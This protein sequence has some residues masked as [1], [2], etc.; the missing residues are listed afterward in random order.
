VSVTTIHGGTA[1]N[2]LPPEVELGE[3]TYSFLLVQHLLLWKKSASRGNWR[4]I[5]RLDSGAGEDCCLGGWVVCFRAHVIRGARTSLSNMKVLQLVWASSLTRTAFWPCLSQ[6]II[7]CISAI[8][9]FV[10]SH[11]SRYLCLLGLCHQLNNE[12]SVL[13]LGGLKGVCSCR[14]SAFKY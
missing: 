3:A 4:L 14:P 13:L 1:L 5:A 10:I 11:L 2:V 9:P 12:D 6:S 7:I 8:G